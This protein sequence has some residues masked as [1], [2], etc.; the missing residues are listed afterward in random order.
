MYISELI[1]LLERLQDSHGDLP[2]GVSQYNRGAGG[3]YPIDGWED[4]GSYIQLTTD[5]YRALGDEPE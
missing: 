1:R 2:V 4:C 5:L 3:E